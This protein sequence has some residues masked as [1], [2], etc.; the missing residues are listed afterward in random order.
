[1]VVRC[2]NF[3]WC[4]LSCPLSFNGCLQRFAATRRAGVWRRNY[5]KKLMI[6]LLFNIHEKTEIRLL[7]RCCYLLAFYLSLRIL[8][9]ILSGFSI[10]YVN[11]SNIV[12]V[13]TSSAIC[14]VFRNNESPENSIKPI[15]FPHEFT[16]FKVVTINVSPFCSTEKYSFFK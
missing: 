12:E 8:Y 13:Q 2:L 10:L 16:S 14:L 4:L 5:F 7:G 6:L 11:F 3:C 9:F 15:V 1:M